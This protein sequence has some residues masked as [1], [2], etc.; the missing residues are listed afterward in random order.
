[1]VSM[2]ENSPGHWRFVLRPNRS[3]TWREM[4][5]FF[6]II[7]SVSV[8]IAMFFT[9]MGFWP[10]MP[11][12]GAELAFLWFCLCHN[13]AAGSATEVIDIDGE[14]VA[15]EQGRRAP[16]R[17]W[18]FPRCWAQIRLEPPTARLHPSRLVIGSHGRRVLLGAFL[19]E[20][21]RVALASEL[22]NTISRSRG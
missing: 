3:A 21:E 12:A 17:R 4:K 7:A 8:T 14:S 2:V 22:R 16:E 20:D 13:A 10:V 15:V 9:F 18:R 6:A 5:I 19:T 1:M 11:F